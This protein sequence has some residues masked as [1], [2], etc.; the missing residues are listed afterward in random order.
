MLGQAPGGQAF[1]IEL[2]RQ[3]S[4][5]LHSSKKLQLGWMPNR[6]HFI[7]MRAGL[8]AKAWLRELKGWRACS[9][10]EMTA[11]FSSAI[12]AIVA[13][14]PRQHALDWPRDDSSLPTWNSL[15][16]EIVTARRAGT[17]ALVRSL[18]SSMVRRHRCLLAIYLSRHILPKVI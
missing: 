1:E 17:Y 15:A 16:A 6:R 13:N 2:I 10:V 3:H 14:S 4:V 7:C 12:S 8:F 5:K 18:E 9:I 11:A